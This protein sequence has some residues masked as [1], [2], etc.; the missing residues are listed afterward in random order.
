MNI[1]DIF[2]IISLTIFYILFLGRT[3]LLYRNG[4]KVWVIG[5][6]TKKNSEIILEKILMPLALVISFIFI[7][8][9]ALH[10]SLPA[11]ISIIFIKTP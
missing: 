1:I 3:I 7:I 5:T 6:S 4:I 8:I 2:V 11:K 10:I 9:T